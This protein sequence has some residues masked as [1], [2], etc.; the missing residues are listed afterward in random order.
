SGRKTRVIPS[1]PYNGAAKRIENIWTTLNKM[2]WRH[3]Q[4]S[5]PRTWC[6]WRHWSP[7]F[8]AWAGL[9]SAPLRAG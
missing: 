5:C 4:G 3:M 6:S 1:L 2:V 9:I 7:C 8:P